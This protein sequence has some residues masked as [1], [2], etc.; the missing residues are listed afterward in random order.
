MNAKFN[1]KTIVGLSLLGLAVLMSYAT[2]I[3]LPRIGQVFAWIMDRKYPLARIHGAINLV[4]DHAFFIGAVVLVILFVVSKSPASLFFPTIILAILGP[5]LSLVG[6]LIF[7]TQGYNFAEAFLGQ[8]SDLGYQLRM[9]GTYP[10]LAGLILLLT[11]LKPRS[12]SIVPTSTSRFDPM[13]GEPIVASPTVQPVANGGV[14]SNLP[15]V[16]LILAFFVPLAAVI[17]GHI[18]LSQMKQG[19]ITSRNLSMAKAGLI[20]G[21]VFIGLGFLL[22]IIFAVVYVLA[23]SRGY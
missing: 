1:S 11:S 8:Y 3:E 7:V 5:G 23:M 10:A 2:L 17:V 22:G 4:S 12:K 19:L 6:S 15:L 16:A 21:Y 9:L 20:L 14:E 13:T 18:S